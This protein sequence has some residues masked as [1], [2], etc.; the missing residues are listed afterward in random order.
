MLMYQTYDQPP[1]FVCD[2]LIN[3]RHGKIESRLLEGLCNPIIKT[4]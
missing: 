1:T 4:K 2:A 3:D